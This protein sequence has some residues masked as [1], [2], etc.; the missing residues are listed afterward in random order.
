M[1]WES[2]ENI[3][4]ALHRFFGMRQKSQEFPKSWQKPCQVLERTRHAA[5]PHRLMESPTKPH[6]EWRA[7]L[8]RVYSSKFTKVSGM[9]RGNVA[10][11]FLKQVLGVLTGSDNTPQTRVWASFDGPRQTN[12]TN[13]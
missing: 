8:L 9:M 5:T 1:T 3:A 7:Q 2:S 13:G 6:A 4:A 11:C 10:H 12:L